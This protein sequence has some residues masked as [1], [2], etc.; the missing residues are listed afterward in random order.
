MVGDLLFERTDM[1]PM[2]DEV[3]DIETERKGHE[4]DED[5]PDWS[6]GN[7]H[8]DEREQEQRQYQ[9]AAEDAKSL[10][11]ALRERDDEVEVATQRRYR[12]ED[13]R[14]KDSDLHCKDLKIAAK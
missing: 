5:D 3:L 7:G 10:V 13:T 6:I 9:E 12:K 11:D 14:C 2:I 8:E 1:T 4:S